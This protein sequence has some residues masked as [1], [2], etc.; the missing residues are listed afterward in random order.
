MSTGQIVAVVVLVV[1]IAVAV[2]AVMF[3]RRRNPNARRLEAEQHWREA[4]QRRASAQRLEAEASHRA[5]RARAEQA[6]AAELAEMARHDREAAEKAAA[7]AARLDPDGTLAASA[8]ASHARDEHPAL[9]AH[10]D[11]SADGHSDHRPDHRPDHRSDHADD[12]QTD[13]LRTERRRTHYVEPEPIV[14]GAAEG[15]L[16]KRRAEHR[17]PTPRSSGHDEISPEQDTV[18]TPRPAAAD[19]RS[20]GATATETHPGRTLADRIMGR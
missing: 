3:F 14:G 7:K 18:P 16:E 12:Q 6:Q 10:A 2:G 13:R 19:D 11:P 9:P 4:E 20:G 8:A 1:L 5:E 15:L 17:V